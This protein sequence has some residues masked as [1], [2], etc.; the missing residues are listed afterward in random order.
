LRLAAI[1]LSAHPDPERFVSEFSGSERT[2][3]G[4]LFAEV[5]ERRP[6][7]VR[8][9]LLRTSI[10]E[11]VSGQPADVLTARPG[12]SHRTAISAESS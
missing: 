7:E 5:L 4:C 9:L 6:P 8:D 3:A 2:V 11:R 1:S 10:L 12:F